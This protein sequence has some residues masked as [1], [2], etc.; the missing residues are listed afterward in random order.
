MF[1]I[2]LPDVLA[3]VTAAFRRY[4]A[5]LLANDVAALD[6]FFWDSPLAVR[7]GVNEN[8]YGRDAIAAF[9][10]ARTLPAVTRQLSDTLITTFGRDYATVHTLFQ[11]RGSPRCGRQSQTW[12]RTEAG[13]RI[14]GAHVS[15]LESAPTELVQRA[16]E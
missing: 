9:R 8:L 2:N 7:Y 5:A 11:W 1:E 3:E 14:V 12:L 13:W 4:E 10:G 16:P 15:Y 6:R